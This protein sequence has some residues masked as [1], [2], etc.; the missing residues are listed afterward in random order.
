M[1]HLGGVTVILVR[2]DDTS[3]GSSRELKGHGRLRRYISTVLSSDPEIS[4]T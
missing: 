1:D 3:S 4:G 2:E